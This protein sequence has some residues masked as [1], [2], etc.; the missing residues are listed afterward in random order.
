VF[1]TVSAIVPSLSLPA[2]GVCAH[3]GEGL[4]KENPSDDRRLKVNPSKMTQR[5][6]TWQT[7][8]DQVKFRARTLIAASLE[9]SRVL[10]SEA[11]EKADGLVPNDIASWTVCD[12]GAP[13]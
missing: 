13:R 4:E 11:R 7:R 9:P 3:L 12:R 6:S 1:T 2:G 8:C 10:L 5:I